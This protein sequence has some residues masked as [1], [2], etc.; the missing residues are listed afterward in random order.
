MTLDRKEATRPG[1]WVKK[2]TTFD[3]NCEP[4]RRAFETILPTQEP[5]LERTELKKPAML[6]GSWLNQVSIDWIAFGIVTVKKF[7]I[8]PHTWLA[9]V[10]IAFQALITALRNPS[11][12]V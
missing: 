7:T 9:V 2:F 10:L 8:A 4:A 5:T 6:P 1:S 12:V 11:L 3:R